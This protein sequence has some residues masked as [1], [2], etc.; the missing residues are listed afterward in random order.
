M[1]ITINIILVDPRAVAGSV[2]M[3]LGL[4]GCININFTKKRDEEWLSVEITME[5]IHFRESSF[6][7]TRGGGGRKILKLEA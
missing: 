2:E 6:N 7:M 1:S 4:Q 5:S 3:P